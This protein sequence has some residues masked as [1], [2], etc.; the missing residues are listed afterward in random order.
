[1][2]NSV[3]PNSLQFPQR[4]NLLF[5]D[6]A[7]MS[8]RS[9]VETMIGVAMFVRRRI[10]QPCRRNLRMPEDRHLVNEVQVDIENRWTLSRS[11]DNV[12]VP[13]FFKHGPRCGRIGI[14]HLVENSE[15]N[16][17]GGITV[18]SERQ[19][20]TAQTQRTALE[21]S[22]LLRTLN[23]RLCLSV[24]RPIRCKTADRSNVLLSRMRA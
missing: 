7:A 23:N 2:S 17:F 6:W 4:F 20:S 1:M 22:I 13:D 12:L 24:R 3:T 18:N 19:M 10:M 9:E 8:T 5:T 15:R 16:Q 11:M 14:R 21:R